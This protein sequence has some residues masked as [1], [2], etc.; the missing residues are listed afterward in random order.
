MNGELAFMASAG[1]PVAKAA[2]KVGEDRAAKILELHPSA[3][4]RNVLEAFGL[5][6][7]AR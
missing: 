6:E 4:C 3:R 2:L 1:C 7:R 5:C